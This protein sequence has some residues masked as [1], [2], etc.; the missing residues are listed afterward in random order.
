MLVT[1]VGDEMCWCHRHRNWV[2]NI[3]VTDFLIIFHLSDCDFVLGN[4][5]A[6]SHAY[7]SIGRF[8]LWLCNLQ[9]SEWY[10]L[11]RY[12]SRTSVPTVL[13]ALLLWFKRFRNSGIPKPRV[14]L[15][16]IRNVKIFEL[17]P[18]G[19]TAGQLM[20]VWLR[21]SCLKPVSKAE[22]QIFIPYYF[23]SVQMRHRLIPY[24]TC[25][26]SKSVFSVI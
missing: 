20:L 21:Q 23:I 17:I 2:T 25:T 11:S 13:G 15:M 12:V 18:R 6:Y 8:V 19:L 26:W 7:I 24:L 14:N 22:W 16:I 10:I 1:G 9:A 4:I 3:T 5:S